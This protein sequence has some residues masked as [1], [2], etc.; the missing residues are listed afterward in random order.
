MR[1]WQKKTNNKV[2]WQSKTMWTAVVQG[3][4]G[5]A[6]V[7]LA[8]QPELQTVGWIAISKSVI[9]T[10]LRTTTKQPLERKLI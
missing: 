10:Y 2:W 4:A 6:A 7:F 3:V 5:V 8:E 9:D 1:I